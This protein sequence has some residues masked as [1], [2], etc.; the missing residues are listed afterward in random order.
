LDTDINNVLGVPLTSNTALEGF[1]GNVA[2]PVEAS[3]LAG[4][5]LVT[6]V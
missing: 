4:V 2:V 5:R 3:G 6:G 1:P